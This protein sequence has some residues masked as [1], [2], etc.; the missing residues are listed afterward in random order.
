M[1]DKPYIYVILLLLICVFVGRL[2]TVFNSDY[3]LIETGS[4]MENFCLNVAYV[5]GW[6]LMLSNGS[7]IKTKYFKITQGLM[8]I[9]IVGALLKIMY[10]TK[11]ADYLIVFGLAGIL[12]AYSI[13]FYKKP[14]KK[15]LDYLKITWVILLISC[16]ILIFLHVLPIDYRLI[17]DVVFWIVLLDFSFSKLNVK[18]KSKTQL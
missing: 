2:L 1:K 4:I 9:I 8:S 5:A 18:K 10:W 13:S 16:I 3:E 17:A 11:Y 7:F 12:I 14:I 6:V 15:R